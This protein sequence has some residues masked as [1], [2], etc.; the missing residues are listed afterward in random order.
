MKPKIRSVHMTFPSGD[1]K[2]Y[3]TFFRGE[4]ISTFSRDI[5]YD[6]AET[7][8]N[9]AKNKLDN[10]PITMISGSPNFVE[11]DYIKMD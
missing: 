4:E 9:I 1:R 6:R 8:A 5:S 7:V 11:V 10:S 2:P 3:V